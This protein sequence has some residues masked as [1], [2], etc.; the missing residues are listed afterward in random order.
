MKKAYSQLKVSSDKHRVLTLQGRKSKWGQVGVNKSKLPYI[1]YPVMPI[2][3]RCGK[4][5]GQTGQVLGPWID[6]LR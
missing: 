4:S 2:N 5:M 3:S 1:R 6:K